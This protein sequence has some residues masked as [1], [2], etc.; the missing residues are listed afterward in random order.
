MKQQIL[1]FGNGGHA[2][3]LKDLIGKLGYAI[4]GIFDDTVP[5]DTSFKPDAKMIIAIGSNKVRERISEE[6]KHEYVTLIHPT[7]V[8]GENVTIGDGT[9]VLANVV[10]QPNTKIGKHCI[11]NAGAII[12]HDVVIE[13]F[14]SIYPG[15]YIGSSAT[16]TR[17]K[18]VYPNQV[19]ERSVVY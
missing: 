1:L 2:N 18:T 5:Y 19:V 10:I 11:I 9:V 13:D 7:A 16:I 17:C 15:A 4:T 3:V 12:D 6:T 14:S 8:I